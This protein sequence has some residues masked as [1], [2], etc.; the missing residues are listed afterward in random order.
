MNLNHINI[1]LLQFVFKNLIF[2]VLDDKID[3]SQHSFTHIL[4]LLFLV[5]SI[6][7]NVRE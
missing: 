3:L 4:L 1:S 5:T 6:G 7:F 2:L